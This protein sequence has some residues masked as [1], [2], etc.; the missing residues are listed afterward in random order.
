MRSSAGIVAGLFLVALVA[1]CGG[2]D[3]GSPSPTGGSTG[4]GGDGGTT[5]GGSA[6]STSKG[7]SSGSTN[8]G[9]GGGVTEPSGCT[10]ADDCAAN[11]QCIDDVCKKEDGQACTGAEECI[12]TCIDGSCTAL[13]DDGEDCTADE[14]CAHTC[15]DGVCAPKSQVGGDCDVEL[16]PDGEG[17]AGGQGAGVGGQGAGGLSSGGQGAGGLSSGGAPSGSGGEA[18]AAAV[19]L[20]PSKDCEAPLQCYAGKCLTPDG[21]AC[22]D[23]VDCLNTCVENV[24][25]TKGTIDGA[26]DDA[27]DCAVA[28][29]VC[30]E[31]TATC[32]LDLLQQCTDNAQCK[33]ERCICSD[34][35]CSVRVCK[36]PGSVCQ[37]KWS[38]ADSVT[39]NNTSANLNAQTQDPNG[40]DVT[41]ANICSNGQC[42]TNVGGDCAQACQ[43]VGNGN[44]GM[45]GTMDD[46]CAPNGAATGC[47]AGY[48]AV[49]KSTPPGCHTAKNIQG[50]YFCTTTCACELN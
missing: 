13:L 11:E 47:N 43:T 18:G 28:A 31:A 1:N 37:C 42:V 9:G 27:A 40:C 38:P 15:I 20:P 39:C 32:K 44:D 7:G 26:C 4:E 16:P 46:V 33:S 2:D 48:G 49:D 35:N 6:G 34:A 24:C 21:E 41:T 12:N 45:A 29:L 10:S 3:N 17:G 50:T 30:D 8:N 25:T 36:Q 23:N 14:D 22:T 19:P 5:K